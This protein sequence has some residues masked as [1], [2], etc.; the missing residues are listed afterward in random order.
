V[1]VK[2]VFDFKVIEIMWDKES[3]HALLGIFWA[4]DNYAVIDLNKDIGP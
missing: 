3:Y 1:G 2:I 4:Y